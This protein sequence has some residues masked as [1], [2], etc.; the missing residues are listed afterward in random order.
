MSSTNHLALTALED[1]WSPDEKILFLGEWCRKFERRDYWETLD[2]EL[3]E[4]PFSKPD[5]DRQ[6]YCYV[7]SLKEE[8]LP[9]LA[10]QLNQ[11]HG[12]QFS[13]RYW[14]I[15][16]GPWLDNYIAAYYDRYIHL[17]AALNDYPD[18]LTVL[19]DPDDCKLLDD[20]LEWQ[21][22][23]VTDEFN[24]QIFSRILHAMGYDFPCARRTQPSSYCK[25]YLLYRSFKGKVFDLL[26]SMHRSTF[27]RM[28]G[29]SI[30]MKN[31]Y[32]SRVDEL[33]FLWSMQGK[34]FLSRGI[35]SDPI[36]YVDGSE[37]REQL[38]SLELNGDEFK[39]ILTSLLPMDLPRSFLEGYQ[40]ICQSVSK[41]YPKSCKAIF[42]A[43][44]W[45]SDDIFKIWAA[46][47]AERGSILMGAAHGGNYGALE[48]LSTEDHEI[49]ITDR[50]YSWGWTRDCSSTQIIP[51]PVQKLIS[52]KKISSSQEREGILWVGTSTPRY[53][54]LPGFPS[55]H[56][57][58]YIRWSERFLQKMS[59]S[60]LL[61]QLLFRPHMED[62]SWSLTDR[63]HL[64]EP[65]LD[66]DTWDVL[67]QDRLRCNRLY[68]CDHLST[69][70]IEALGT[71]MPTVLF[72]NP[73]TVRL[74]KEAEPYFDLLRESGILF[75]SPEGAAA[76]VCSIYGNVDK[77]WGDDRRVEAVNKFC[78]HFART[79]KN[80]FSGWSD[81]LKRALESK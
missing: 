78:Y 60:D 72:W 47:E 12:S 58:D 11:I 81:E 20:T 52:C 61:N 9:L 3:L 74:R 30:V 23:L 4:S 34:M 43:N 64:I 54:S 38:T 42:S 67:L 71:R 50:Y 16:V 15:V 77:W 7:L 56:Y 37:M 55:A 41:F 21:A 46:K 65:K 49:K 24:L 10:E 79:E 29:T 1:F 53:L 27:L 31:S 40:S 17:K 33:R 73:S 62:F 18:L 57:E 28:T 48:C 80:G 63:L 5:L 25:K 19:L 32:F 59:E 45:F 35:D 6:A 76:A 75:D 44:A 36:D 68:V 26:M 8:I 69:T 2:Y 39:L 22:A 70:F 66:I 13:M 51:M 14:R